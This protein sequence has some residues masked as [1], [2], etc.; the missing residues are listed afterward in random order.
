MI[1]ALMRTC[2]PFNACDEPFEYGHGGDGTSRVSR[3]G[4]PG[5]VNIIDVA[6]TTLECQLLMI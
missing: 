1:V 2:P 6:I 4:P 5:D 3:R